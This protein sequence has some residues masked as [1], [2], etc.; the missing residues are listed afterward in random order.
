MKEFKYNSAFFQ[1]LTKENHRWNSEAVDTYNCI[2][3]AAGDST[4]PWWPFYGNYWPLPFPPEEESD[5]LEA[6]VEG[7]LELDYKVCENGNLED[8]YEKVALYGFKREAETTIK[9]AA[10]QFSN[11]EWGSKMGGDKSPDIVH[12]TPEAVVGLRYGKIL[13][14]LKRPRRLG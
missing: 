14:F 4:Q 10:I 5:S 12:S 7:F 6:F 2:A 1:N 11:G 3:F 13:Q 8:G 9:H